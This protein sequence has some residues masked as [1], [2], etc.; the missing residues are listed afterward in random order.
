MGSDSQ[1]DEDSEREEAQLLL[2]VVRNQRHVH[3]LE[4]DVVVAQL[5]ENAAIGELYK[6]RAVRAQKKLGITEHDLGHLRNAIRKSGI[7]L[8]D[9]PSTRKRRRL[10]I[11]SPPDGMVP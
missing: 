3:Q 9:L 2:K 8:A 11:D 5:E 4:Q 6:F 7:S 1:C 10:S